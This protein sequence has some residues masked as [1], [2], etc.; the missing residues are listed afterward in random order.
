MSVT[1][2][3][4]QVV[5]LLSGVFMQYSVWLFFNPIRA[6]LYKTSVYTGII[7]Q[8]AH[9]SFL[10]TDVC[11]LNELMRRLRWS[12]CCGSNTFM[13]AK[14]QRAMRQER[15]CEVAPQV[16]LIPL[17]RISREGGERRQ[18][19]GGGKKTQPKKQQNNLRWAEGTEHVTASEDGSAQLHLSLALVAEP[20]LWAIQKLYCIQYIQY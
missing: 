5:V 12:T 9:F 1:N 8:H 20:T 17:P 11:L 4:I 15:R 19:T 18:R 13:N 7:Y 14:L 10:V 6:Q 2:R 3:G 16:L